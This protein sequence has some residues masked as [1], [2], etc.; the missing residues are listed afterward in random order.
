VILNKILKLSL[1]LLILLPSISWS[2]D[3][4]T[5]S[6]GISKF[7]DLKYPK[8][9]QHFDYVNP[10]APKYGDIKLASLGSFDNLNPFILQGTSVEGIGMI[11]DSLTAGSADESDSQYGLI[12]ESIEIPSDHSWAAFNLRK[13]ARWQDGS[14]IT[15]DDVVFSF[16]ILKT[17]GTPS[18]AAAFRDIKSAEKLSTYKVKFNFTDQ[19][20]RDLPLIAGSMP[21]ISKSYYEKHTFNKTTMEAP[22]GSG[23]YKVKELVPGR[24]ITYELDENYWA[25]NLPVNVGKYN[26]KTMK[27]DY[28]RDTTVAIEALKAHEYDYRRENIAK[29]WANTYNIPQISDGRMVKE[30]IPDGTPTGMQC[31]A[32]NIRRPSLKNIKLREA[33]NYAY[34]FEWANKQ[35]FFSAYTRNI[36]YYGNSDF[37]SSGLPSEDEIKLL[38]PFA[39][40]LPKELFTQPFELPKYGGVIFGRLNLFQ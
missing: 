5:V 21:I 12:A 14:K 33:L 15:A 27:F 39:D 24:S 10:N 13:Q 16:N 4:V 40:I 23:P 7:G 28:Y 25:K 32:F 18:Y 19:T 6:Y 35:L 38:K 22:L 9:F 8:N 2:A 31:F 36:S 34:D 37:A 26:F 17:Q 20:N 11:F 3:K 30:T 29:I 1:F